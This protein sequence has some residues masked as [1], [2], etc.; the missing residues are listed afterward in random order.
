MLRRAAGATLTVMSG[1]YAV[2]RVR[3]YSYD[4][5]RTEEERREVAKIL[6]AFY[7]LVDPEGWDARRLSRL[8]A[9]EEPQ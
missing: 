4:L 5:L 6:R 7:A 3:E 9:G 2:N 8:A 1:A